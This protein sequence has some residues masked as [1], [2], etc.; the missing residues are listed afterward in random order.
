MSEKKY[1]Q[2]IQRAI[3]ILNLIAD[4]GSIKLNDICIYTGLKTSTA[5]GILQT[6]EFE[7]QV[8]RINN[9]LEYALGLNSLKLGLS[10][11]EE[12]G[13]SKNIHNLLQR[14][15]DIVDET[16]YFALQVGD[17]FYYHDFVLSSKPLKVVPEV[18]QFIDLPTNS[19]IGQ[20]FKEENFNKSYSTDLE[21]VYEGMNC[22]AIPYRS[23]DKIVG[24][25]AFSGPSNRFTQEKISKAYD[26]Y[27]KVI[28]E[29]GFNS[30]L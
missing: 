10:Y 21:Y 30:H 13:I 18:G 22:M 29:L 4:K 26:V 19:A 1:I 7:G 23:K 24:C 17:R 28:E 11:L 25:I 9:G 20:V 15:V 3:K 14:L 27:L 16:T 12:S 6:L 2:S 8:C 5:F